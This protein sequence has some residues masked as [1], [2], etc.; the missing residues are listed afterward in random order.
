MATV[1][2]KKVLTL[3]PQLATNAIQEKWNRNYSLMHNIQYLLLWVSQ[4]KQNKRDFLC[5]VLGWLLMS[6]PALEESRMQ[7]H[8]FWMN[9]HTQHLMC[10]CVLN[11]DL[12]LVLFADFLPHFLSLSA[13][14]LVYLEQTWGFLWFLITD[15]CVVFVNCIVGNI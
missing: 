12:R 10:V 13:F 8:A 2:M 3:T 5:F 7:S 4:S 14:D 15:N 6:W 1:N 9:K 11:F